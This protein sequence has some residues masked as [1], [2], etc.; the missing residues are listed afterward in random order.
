MLMAA[1]PSPKRARG[2]PKAQAPLGPVRFNA[3]KELIRRIEQQRARMQAQ[4]PGMQIPLSAAI[5]VLLLKGLEVAERDGSP[6]PELPL[7]ESS[8]KKI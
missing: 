8:T 3:D 6:Q 1:K 7:K 4:N 2:R 5:R